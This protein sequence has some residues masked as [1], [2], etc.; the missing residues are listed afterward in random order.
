[1]FSGASFTSKSAN[2]ASLAAGTVQLSSS[3]SQAIIAETSGLKP[4]DSRKGTITITNK[5]DVASGLTLSATGLTG[6]ALAAVIDLKVDEVTD[7][8]TQKWSGKLSSFE[9]LS[10]GSLGASAS[11]TFQLTLSWPEASNSP[12]LQAAST[13]LT[14]VWSG[15]A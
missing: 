13:S 8:T 4:G 14:F 9:S 1:M 11:R 5:G 2:K 3:T 10:L 7:T 15:S 12:A 6:S